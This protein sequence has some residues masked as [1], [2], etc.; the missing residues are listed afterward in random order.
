ML[1]DKGRSHLSGNLRWLGDCFELLLEIYGYGQ[2]LASAAEAVES[3]TPAQMS[4]LERSLASAEN[5][6][7]Q[8]DSTQP[9]A[10]FLQDMGLCLR[11][12]VDS[13][14]F[15]EAEDAE[16]SFP[17]PTRRKKVDSMYRMACYS[18]KNFSSS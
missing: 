8:N 10:A 6:R 12:C 9:L 15:I 7:F 2:Q 5:R 11:N 18:P 13:K 1:S 3:K 17:S 4:R 16:V 14:G